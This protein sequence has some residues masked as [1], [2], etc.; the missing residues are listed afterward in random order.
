MPSPLRLFLAAVVIGATLFG[1]SA[2]AGGK[3]ASNTIVDVAVEA[4]S[5][6][7]LVTALQAADLADTL[8][9]DGPFTVFAPTDEA[10]AKL[11]AET[12][13]ALLADPKALADILTYH[14]VAGRTLSG[15]IVNVDSVTTL[16]GGSL[17][18]SIDG[19]VTIGDA[20]VVTVDVLASNGV[21]HVID[22]V[23]VP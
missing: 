5:F 14:V 13:N 10:F 11:P 9:G 15:E 16:Q 17:D 6:K 2:A 3:K 4:G 23:L 7:T 20:S 1:L 18:V 8:A 12:L 19:G 22:S 21:I